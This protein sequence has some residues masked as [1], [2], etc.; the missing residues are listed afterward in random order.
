MTPLRNLSRKTLSWS[1]PTELTSRSSP[2]PHPATSEADS[3]RFGRTSEVL[4]TPS[5][6]MPKRVVTEE[7]ISVVAVAVS[8]RM[9]G[10]RSLDFRA[11]PSLRYDGRKLCA[12]SEAQ[13]TCK[14]MHYQPINRPRAY[15]FSMALKF[16]FGKSCRVWK[17]WRDFSVAERR[18][19]FAE[20]S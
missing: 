19:V 9:Q 1:T 5:G 4:I 17:P 3:L 20:S 11:R 7:I 12:H 15:I 14:W 16:Y 18:E 2:E 13:C 6:G 8:P 10:T